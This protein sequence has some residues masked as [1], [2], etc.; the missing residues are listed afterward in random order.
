MPSAKQNLQV[1]ESKASRFDFNLLAQKYE[2]VMTR[3]ISNACSE[4]GRDN[5]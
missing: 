1:N 4:V 2:V 3:K 5:K